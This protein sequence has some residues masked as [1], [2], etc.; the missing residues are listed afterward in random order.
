M[1]SKH[2]MAELAEQLK[3][4]RWAS[5][6]V[7]SGLAQKARTSALKG[8]TT[9]HQ[10]Q[11]HLSR[12]EDRT[13][14]SA[15]LSA[16]DGLSRRSDIDAPPDSIARPGELTDDALS[17]DLIASA[18]I[19]SLFDASEAKTRSAL[20][21]KLRC[22][23]EAAKSGQRLPDELVTALV[24]AGSAFILVKYNAALEVSYYHQIISE[25]VPAWVQREISI[26]MSIPR[27]Q[28]TSGWVLERARL[29]AER[30]PDFRR[31]PKPVP[32]YS[33]V[34]DPRARNTQDRL[35]L[36]IRSWLGIP[37][38]G[39]SPQ[40]V[41]LVAVTFPIDGIF[42]DRTMRNSPW[43]QAFQRLVARSR[44]AL[45]LA[46][47]MEDRMALLPMGPSPSDRAYD[48]AKVGEQ[49][50]QLLPDFPTPDDALGF[51]AVVQGDQPP[52]GPPDVH[53]QLRRRSF[54]DPLYQLVELASSFPDHIAPMATRRL[55]VLNTDPA[56]RRTLTWQ[57][58][59]RLPG[60]LES[61]YPLGVRDTARV[62]E[63][64]VTTLVPLLASPV[65]DPLRLTLERGLALHEGHL[66]EGPVV[67]LVVPIAGLSGEVEGYLRFNC[68]R[69][70]EPDAK[71][72]DMYEHV[73]TGTEQLRRRLGTLLEALGVEVTEA[74]GS[75]A[76]LKLIS[77]VRAALCETVALELARA[78]YPDDHREPELSRLEMLLAAIAILELK[79][80]PDAMFAELAVFCASCSA[81]RAELPRVVLVSFWLHAERPVAVE[82]TGP[83]LAE[84][85]MSDRSLARM[86]HLLVEHRYAQ[87]EDSAANMDANLESH[88]HLRSDLAVIPP[89]FVRLPDGSTQP[90]ILRVEKDARGSVITHLHT[91]D[92]QWEGSIRWAMR[93]YPRPLAFQVVPRGITRNLFW[94][95]HSKPVTPSSVEYLEELDP[96]KLV[97]DPS[98]GTS[99]LDRLI[100]LMQFLALSAP[101]ADRPI[102]WYAKKLLSRSPGTGGNAGSA[103]IW[104]VGRKFDPAQRA[105]ALYEAARRWRDDGLLLQHTRSNALHHA[106]GKR[107]QIYRTLDRVIRRV[108][109]DVRPELLRVSHLLGRLDF[110]I[111]IDRTEG[112]RLSGKLDQMLKQMSKWHTGMVSLD[113]QAGKLSFRGAAIVRVAI[114]FDNL[115][116]NA[117]EQAQ[118]SGSAAGS[119]A[120]RSRL[121]GAGVVVQIRNPGRM[122]PIYQSYI[123]GADVS[124]PGAQAPRGRGLEIVR[125]TVDDHRWEMHANVEDDATIVSVTIKRNV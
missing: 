14:L 66:V 124:Y 79:L 46:L 102:Q 29:A 65:L 81:R 35:V 54:A 110:L 28:G 91:A 69:Q 6:E 48:R 83:G 60:D 30:W 125:K 56:L 11:T 21:T 20:R 86:L 105:V 117:V 71:F 74:R 15:W 32:L 112:S 26:S 115:L 24:A 76:Q 1:D 96:A 3:L 64:A 90:L 106:M 19:A 82:P 108:P 39:D 50:R 63:N 44:S 122:D 22:G 37:I 62:V 12:E 9:A 97:R 7:L 95:V 5:G 33:A 99:V 67:D 16:L 4:R 70:N 34:A 89:A 107:A 92:R 80:A 93:R 13:R 111:S 36:G 68:A 10:I 61:L 78:F 51:L 88:R 17:A 94:D 43:V 119:V 116:M 59:D 118:N 58:Q 31:D 100:E 85:L 52:H 55:D 87:G 27:W 123:N 25:L 109:Q 8:S 72:H 57:Q 75:L 120:V 38:F 101:R 103:W 42:Y 73:R 47:D 41:G 98:T 121:E 2:I 77:G 40:P 23:I 18:P 49:A 114:L 113:L 104:A 45:L 84:L 53:V